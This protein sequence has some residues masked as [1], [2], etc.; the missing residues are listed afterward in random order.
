MPSPIAMPEKPVNRTTLRVQIPTPVAEHYQAIADQT[1]KAVEDIL[2]ERL[3]T[4]VDYYDEE[5]GRPLHFTNN[6]RQ[7][8]EQLLGKNVFST[9]DA[10]V[11]V[12]NSLSIRTGNHK[13]QLKPE[14]LTRL[15]SRCIG[16]EWED[17]LVQT[18]TRELER[19]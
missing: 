1:G 9:R 4:T 14:L 17:F 8:L 15:K 10:L 5:P 13:I 6:E 2:S 11:L 12:R 7:E 19:F 3:V 16:V 18:V